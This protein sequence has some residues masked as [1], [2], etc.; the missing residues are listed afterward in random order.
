MLQ[1]GLEDASLVVPAERRGTVDIL[2]LDERRLMLA[3]RA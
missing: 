2:T 1:L 3:S